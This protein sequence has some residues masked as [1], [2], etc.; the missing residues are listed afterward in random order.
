[1][2]AAVCD[3]SGYLPAVVKVTN[4][5]PLSNETSVTEPTLIPE[6]VTSLPTVMPPASLNSA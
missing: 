4:A 2:C 5:S 6:S 1:M 3:P